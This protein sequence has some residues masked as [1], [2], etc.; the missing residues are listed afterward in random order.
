MD[1]NAR[2]GSVF[3]GVPVRWWMVLV[4]GSRD[5]NLDRWGFSTEYAGDRR[6]T[7]L[8][9]EMG[10]QASSLEP[11]A[12]FSAMTEVIIHCSCDWWLQIRIC[13][14]GGPVWEQGGGVG[15]AGRGK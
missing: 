3:A 14:A 11:H 13:D 9:K 6:W 7:K 5:A 12:A 1:S 4:G 10:S 2:P 8:A 15:R